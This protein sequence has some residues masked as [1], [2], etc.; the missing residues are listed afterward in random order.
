ME[1]KDF[2]IYGSIFIF[3]ILKEQFAWKW[4][5]SFFNGAQMVIFQNNILVV[6]FHTMKVNGDWICNALKQQNA[7]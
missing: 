2:Y 3:P 4:K 5:L 7:A 6:L 1:K